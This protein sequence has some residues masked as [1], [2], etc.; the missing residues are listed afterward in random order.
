MVSI[1][2]KKKPQGFSEQPDGGENG[3]EEEEGEGGKKK[4]KKE[5]KL[6]NAQGEALPPGVVVPRLW[7]G[8]KD[9]SLVLDYGA[10]IHFWE[11]S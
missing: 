11:D 4:K 1:T 6:E 10:T 7:P 2:E 3:E 9:T 5:K 8:L